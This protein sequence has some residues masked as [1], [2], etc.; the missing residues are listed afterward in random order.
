MWKGGEKCMEDQKLKRQ[1]YLKDVLDKYMK[2]PPE[3][4][5]NDIAQVIC[6]QLGDIRPLLKEITKELRKV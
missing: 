6:Y 1:E 4:S 2:T 3:L 5:L